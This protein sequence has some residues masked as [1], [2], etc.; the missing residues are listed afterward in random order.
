MLLI[1]SLSTEWSHLH[2]LSLA[3]VSYI[4]NRK[5]VGDARHTLCQTFN[6][7][8][9]GSTCFNPSENPAHIAGLLW[10]LFCF[11]PTASDQILFKGREG[12]CL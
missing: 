2:C 6:L 7:Q 11:I 3:S 9:G 8:S 4:S 5:G 12:L 10:L 1:Y